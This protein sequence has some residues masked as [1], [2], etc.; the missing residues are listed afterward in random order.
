MCVIWLLSETM[1][2]VIVVAGHLLSLGMQ[3]GTLIKGHWE[4]K[5]KN[6]EL[7]PEF[8]VTWMRSS[9]W[10]TVRRSTGKTQSFGKYLYGLI[11][12]VR[13]FPSNLRLFLPIYS[14][15]A[16][17]WRIEVGPGK[18]AFW[19]FKIWWANK[20]TIQITSPCLP[21]GKKSWLLARLFEYV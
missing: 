14:W 15:R 9:I 5:M 12:P 8:G 11:K 7:L 16:F 2:F 20:W 17:V 21:I 18:W 10:K 3:K 19:N 13:G 6:P 4:N 1:T